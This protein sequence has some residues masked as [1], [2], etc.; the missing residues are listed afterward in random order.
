ML[1]TIIDFIIFAPV[2]IFLIWFCWVVGKQA[3]ELLQTKHG[4]KSLL[5]LL[6]VVLFWTW[7]MVAW[8]RFLI[9]MS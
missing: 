9:G 5:N 7:V 1:M 3:Y 8:V 6:A 4:R 2:V